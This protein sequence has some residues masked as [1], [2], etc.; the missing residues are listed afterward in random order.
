M[1]V[2]EFKSAIQ[3]I[4]NPVVA[5]TCTPAA[6]KFCQRYNVKLDEL[7]QRAQAEKRRCV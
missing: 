3:H 6:E 4:Y 2:R 5:I 7:F 1:D